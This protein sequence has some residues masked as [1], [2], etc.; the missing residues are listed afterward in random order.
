[1]VFEDIRHKFAASAK[2]VG[3]IDSLELDIKRQA[4]PTTDSSV[5]KNG[6]FNFIRSG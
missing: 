5:P 2:T 4:K 6:I 1:M 3:V